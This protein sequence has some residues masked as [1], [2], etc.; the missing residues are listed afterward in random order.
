MALASLRKHLMC[1]VPV[2]P[3]SNLLSEV[4]KEIAKRKRRKGDRMKKMELIGKPFVEGEIPDLL[5]E[6]VYP[7]HECVV[8]EHERDTGNSFR[9]LMGVGK[10]GKKNWKRLKDRDPRPY[11]CDAV[12]CSL[13]AK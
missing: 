6:P 1:S 9:V 5:I 8:V 3:A 7:V 2:S 4:K 13:E 12:I 11:L 10:E